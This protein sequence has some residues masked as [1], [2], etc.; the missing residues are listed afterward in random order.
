[1]GPESVWTT[2][3]SQSA[4]SGTGS[5]LPEPRVFPMLHL[6]AEATAA[7][8]ISVQNRF[9]RQEEAC[10]SVGSRS[11]LPCLPVLDSGVWWRRCLFP[12]QWGVVT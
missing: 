3:P 4:P 8:C 11:S 2:V 10:T 5:V 1:M 7:A 6:V 12:G 9:L